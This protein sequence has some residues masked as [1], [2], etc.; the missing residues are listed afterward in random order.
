MHKFEAYYIDN[1]VGEECCTHDSS[2]L[3]IFFLYVSIN[4]TV[5]PIFQGI[6][7]L[8]LRDLQ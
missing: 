5:P 7:K 4:I 1:L 6:N 2:M 3:A 8:T